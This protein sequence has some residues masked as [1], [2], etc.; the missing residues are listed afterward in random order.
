MSRPLEF[1][2]DT[3]LEKAM[4]VFWSKG[5]KATSLDDLV[6][7]MGVSRSSVYNTFGS[8]HRLFLRALTR[9]KQALTTALAS[10]LENSPSVRE[11]FI[12]LFHQIVNTA[13]AGRDRRGCLLSNSAIEMAPKDPVAVAQVAAGFAGVEHVFIRAL[14][15]GQ[16][17]GEL[18]PDLNARA[19]AR[20]LVSSINGL[21]AVS[22]VRPE[23][24]FLNDV[25]K[26]ALSVL[27]R[28]RPKTRR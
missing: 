8:K 15:R 20:F 3:A 1:D 9:Y 25:V 18:S 12:E 7:A 24:A 6:D 13:V 22:K 19:T 4:Q 16:E 2:S 17:S 28:G 11:G 27:D 14:V 10:R 21:R 26:T 23:R 5:Y